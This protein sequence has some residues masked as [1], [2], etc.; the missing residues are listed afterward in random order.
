[1]E[2]NYQLNPNKLIHYNPHFENFMKNNDY[3]NPPI[4]ILNTCNTFGKYLKS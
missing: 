4:F 2:Q 1:M 3:I